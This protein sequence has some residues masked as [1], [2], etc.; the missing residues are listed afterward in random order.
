M[1]KLLSSVNS[2]LFNKQ[3]ARN[4][5]KPPVF[6]ANDINEDKDVNQ[7]STIDAESEIKRIK[8]EL[9]KITPPK[10]TEEQHKKI[11]PQMTYTTEELKNL[12]AQQRKAGSQKALKD[13][14]EQ[15]EES[16]KHS[17]S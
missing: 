16:F 4:Y 2:T 6:N 7:M 3:N 13:T 14:L 15:A 8:K 9:E 10:A 17:H 5:C 11:E 1:K 12:I